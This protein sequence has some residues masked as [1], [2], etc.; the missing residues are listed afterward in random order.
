MQRYALPNFSEIHKMWQLKLTSFPHYLFTNCSCFY[1]GIGGDSI[2]Q[3]KFKVKG[4][5]KI[6]LSLSP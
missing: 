2:F 4:L 5:N 1:L 3:F 6:V